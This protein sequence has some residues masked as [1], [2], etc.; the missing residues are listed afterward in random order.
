MK[1]KY[2]Q[3]TNKYVS[4]YD[5]LNPSIIIQQA[6]EVNEELTALK[7]GLL[8]VTTGRLALQKNYELAVK[9]AK[10]LRDKGYDF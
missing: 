9:A 4:V 7:N 2:P 1:E 6:L 10:I 5:I 8:I 3:L